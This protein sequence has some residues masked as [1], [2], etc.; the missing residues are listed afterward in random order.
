MGVGGQCHASAALP[1]GKVPGTHC[2]G[3]CIG[4]RAGLD[5]FGKSRPPPEF[6]PQTVQPVASPYTYWAI[7][8]HIGGET[9]GKETTW[10]TQATMGG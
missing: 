9:W 4:P 6:D 10:K 1:P 2:I 3:C 7:P 8:A 5:G